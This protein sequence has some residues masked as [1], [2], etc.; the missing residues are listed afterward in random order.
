M[1]STTEQAEGEKTQRNY[2]RLAGFLLL[3]EIIIAAG[4]GFVSSRIAGSGTFA[5]TAKR[6]AA[7]EHLYRAGLAAVLIVSLGSAL[8]A[9]ALYVTLKPVNGLLAKLALIFTLEDSFLALVVRMC[10]FVNAHLYLSTQTLRSE[11]ITAQSLTEL[12]RTVANNTENLGGICFGI[13]SFLFFYLFF[14]SRYIPGIIATLGL[15]A[16]AIWT[17]LYFANLTFPEQH[18]LFMEICLPPM[19]VAEILTGFYLMLFAI[20]DEGRSQLAQ[21][22]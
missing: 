7:S 13:G 16:S 9:F 12:L 3:A 8:L 19:A 21:Q 15:C 10:S 4:G 17:I 20:K 22:A 5:E 11:L 18:K 6:I 2:A 14:Q 1:P